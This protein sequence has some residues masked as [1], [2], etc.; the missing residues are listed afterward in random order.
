[1]ILD[2]AGV[3]IR[4]ETAGAGEP[5][6]LLHGVGSNLESWDGI[7]PAL[8]ERFRVLRY[9]LRGHGQSGTPPG[10]Y[11]LDDFVEDLRRCSTTGASP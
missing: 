1:M 3:V 11:A 5:V 7:V 10:P 8:A 6:T 4:F 9:D 2:R